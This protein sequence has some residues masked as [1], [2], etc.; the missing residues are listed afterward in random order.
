MRRCKREAIKNPSLISHAKDGKS[1]GLKTRMLNLLINV[2]KAS[3]KK[4][5]RLVVLGSL[6]LKENMRKRKV[7]D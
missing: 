4:L 3:R 6:R 2:R 1:Q 5:R 7:V